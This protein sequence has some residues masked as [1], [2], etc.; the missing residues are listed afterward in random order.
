LLI[1]E[2]RDHLRFSRKQR[3]PES[4][5]D[6]SALKLDKDRLAYGNM[7]FICCRNGP[8]RIFMLILDSPPPIVSRYR[9]GECWSRRR[10]RH[11][12]QHNQR[13]E[14]EP[15]QDY[16]GNAGAN[17]DPSQPSAFGSNRPHI[18]G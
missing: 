2:S 15:K 17:I 6:I 4:V 14:D 8:I 11:G 7:Q 5:D 13:I 3:H 9:H 16:G 12:I 18:G 10:L 1:Y